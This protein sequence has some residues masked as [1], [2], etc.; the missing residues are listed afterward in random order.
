MTEP[1]PDT[2]ARPTRR[3]DLWGLAAGVAMGLFD[4]ALFEAIG[5]E[6]RLGGREVTVA[7]MVLFVVTY[8]VLGFAIGRLAIARTRARAD[9]ET[10]AAQLRALAATQQAALQNEKLAAIGR[11]AAGVAHEV[12]NPL[13]VIRA[14]AAM[15]QEGFADGSDGHRA[16]QF[17]REEIDRLNSLI[18]AL[19]TFARPTELH[20]QPVA[21]EGVID[22]ALTLAVE[23][24]AQRRIAV[25]REGGGALPPVPADPDLLAQVVLGLVTNAAE[26]VE[27]GGTIAVRVAREPAAV[28][29]EVADTGPGV[30][31]AHAEQVFEPF[32]TT[33]PTGT[34]LGLAMAARIVRAHGGT[35]DVISG[36]GAGTGGAGACFRVRLLL[37]QDDPSARSAA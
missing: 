33:K 28:C 19:L 12:R 13:G 1:A 10:I 8:A 24:V 34:G 2:P 16:C 17:I 21:L 36:R 25:R 14:S 18:T 26:A 27:P 15:L 20:V 23:V 29:V 3:W 4:L 7:V 31:P 6:M 35:I 22:R 5:V 30:P 37:P 11:L 32:F 9:A